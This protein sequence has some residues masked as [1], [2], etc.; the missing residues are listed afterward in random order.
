[1]RTFFLLQVLN[2]D[3]KAVRGYVLRE[4][5]SSKNYRLVKA[6]R[7]TL[8]TTKSG[9]ANSMKYAL[10]GLG[11]EIPADLGSYS[12]RNFIK[13]PFKTVEVKATLVPA[14]GFLDAALR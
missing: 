7:S 14:E 8:Y 1:M 9:V 6:D 2:P 11:I 12:K 13:Q 4:G 10:E 3:T 5:A